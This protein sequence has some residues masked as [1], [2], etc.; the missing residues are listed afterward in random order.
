MLCSANVMRKEACSTFAKR[1]ALTASGLARV[2]CDAV[3]M[4]KIFLF[5]EQCMVNGQQCTVSHA[6]RRCG[7]PSRV[8]TCYDVM[9]VDD[10]FGLELLLASNMTVLFFWFFPFQLSC[11]CDTIC[12][13]HHLLHF[14]G[15]S[16]HPSL[17]RWPH[18]SLLSRPIVGSDKSSD[19]Q[20]IGW[21]RESLCVHSNNLD[22][23]V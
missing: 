5:D 18:A 16:P 13:N 10:W 14:R 17:D 6:Y 21:Q 8:H 19:K 23:P 12:I 9:T 3:N 22:V 1:S 4:W 15:S 2:H 7:N 11:V 20:L